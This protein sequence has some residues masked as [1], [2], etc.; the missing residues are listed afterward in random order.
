MQLT[1]VR[2]HAFALEWR[3]V[4]C[5]RVFVSPS[6]SVVLI[7]TDETRRVKLVSSLTR[8]DIPVH[9]AAC[10]ADLETWPVGKVLVTNVASLLRFETGAQHVVVL[11][12]SDEERAT[13]AAITDGPATVITGEPTSLLATLRIIAKANRGDPASSG[14][15]DRRGGPPERR[16]YTRRDRRSK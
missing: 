7:D 9:T 6:V 5:A 4:R 13:A 16:R 11:A 14:R 8:E 10:L 12:D 3:C 15:D 2:D 1:R